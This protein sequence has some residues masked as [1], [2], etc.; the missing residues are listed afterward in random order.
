MSP[1]QAPEALLPEVQDPEIFRILV[2]L[3]A[4]EDSLAS[5]DMATRLAA[6]LR[7]ELEGLFVEDINL[8]RMASL[9]CTRVVSVTTT[10]GRGLDLPSMERELRRQGRVARDMLAMNA[11]RFSVRWSFRTARGA[12]ASEI[13]AA[14][15]DADIV[16]ISKSDRAYPQRLKLGNT[17]RMLSAQSPSAVL[18]AHHRFIAAE[19]S[20][21]GAILV[22]YDDTA[23]S[24]RA[25]RLA[26][27]IAMSE[28]HPITVLIPE[29]KRAA[30]RL[31]ITAEAILAAFG[32]Q[33]RIRFVSR[34]DCARL[35][36]IVHAEHGELFVLGCDSPLLRGK[37]TDTVVESLEIP[38]LLIRPTEPEP[39]PDQTT[40][41]A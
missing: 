14:A 1:E 38:V 32:L 7:A 6:K 34:H 4:T 18:I 30:P 41:S 17:A 13:L 35:A 20:P 26:A 27:R 15:A 5:L 24:D 33:P 28:R 12:M 11:E 9:S 39:Q 37:S 19:Y 31:Q 8:L 16:I 2:A 22:A 40:S 36:E 25:L 21:P 23:T 10:S 29:S 3:D